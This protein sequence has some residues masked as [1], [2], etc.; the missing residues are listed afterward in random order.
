MTRR[1]ERFVGRLRAGVVTV[2]GALALLRGAPA[3]AHALSPSMLLLHERSPGIVDATWRTPSLRMPGADIRPILPDQCAPIGS[4]QIDE[5][6]ESMTAHWSVDCGGA[7]LIGMRVGVEG[8]GL[9][10]SDALLHVELADGR[11]I[12]SVIR[13]REPYITIPAPDSWIGVARRYGALGFDHIMGGYDHLLFVF[14]LLLLAPTRRAL[15]GT[16]TAFTVGHSLTLTLAV[17]GITH[18]PPQPIE[19]LIALS[20]FVLAVELSRGTDGATLMRRAPWLMAVTFGFLHGLGF[21]GALR[22]TGL[23]Q[24]AI[25]LSL[26]SFNVGIEVGQL[27]FVAAVL[28]VTA[29]VRPVTL[30][31]PAWSRAVP[32]YVMGSL[33]AFWMIERALPL[34]R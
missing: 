4:E 29:L 7:S 16:I 28:L 25:P 21:A 17:L 9:A 32:V 34:I 22:E 33:A 10:K 8:L 31:L 14:G 6:S 1:S 5:D 19:V 23:P 20:I 18:V 12:D 13:A 2:I 24:T 3:G 30:R 27:A 11:A 26:F 15:L